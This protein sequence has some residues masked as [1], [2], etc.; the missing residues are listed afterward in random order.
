MREHALRF[1]QRLR[2]DRAWSPQSPTCS[3]CAPKLGVKT[4]KDLVALAKQKP[5]A[6]T[7]ASTGVGSP[8]HL[9]LELLADVGRREIPACALSRRGAGADRSARRPGAGVRRRHSGA[10][11]ADQ[12][13]QSGADRRGR[14]ASA[15]PMLPDVPT[16]AEQGYPNTDASNW[17]ALAGAGQDAARDD[18]QD[19]RCGQCRAQR[20][21]GAREADQIR[22]DRRSAARR[23]RSARS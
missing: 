10:D 20:S 3:W 11:V 21:G 14:R 4:I 5:G 8:P 9:A 13:R 12:G 7:F 19:Q 2:A 16:L 23:K 17:Y 18:R 22:R 1:V 6:I 15:M